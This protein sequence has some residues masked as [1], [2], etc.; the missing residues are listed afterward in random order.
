MNDIPLVYQARNWVHGV[1]IGATVGSE[2]TFASEGQVGILRRDPFAMLPF[3]GYHMGDYWKH[4]LSIEKLAKIPAVF[5][6]NWFRKGSDDKFLW[7]GYGENARVLAWM[8]GRVLNNA[9]GIESPLGIIPTYGD[10]DWTGSDFT[11]QQFNAVMAIDS[12]K[13]KAQAEA[14]TDYITKIGTSAGPAIPEL[15]AISEDI[16]AR[17]NA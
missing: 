8:V 12:M 17:C 16:I 2:Q 9:N 13:V 5:H 6:V 14:N 3:C 1:Y 10:F 11:E 15:L 4:Y 7:P